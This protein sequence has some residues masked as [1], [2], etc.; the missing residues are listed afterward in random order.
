MDIREVLTDKGIPFKDTNNPYEILIQCT[1]GEHEDNNASLS[2]NLD[3]DIFNCWS[4]GFKG[5]STKF[6]ASIGVTELLES[7]SKQ[8]FRIRKLKSKIEDKMLK[9]SV[10]LP[11]DKVMVT[12]CFKNIH[13]RVLIEF[14]AFTTDSLGLSDYFCIPV[15]QFNKLRFIEG[16]LQYTNSDHKS[17]YNRRPEKAITADCL[18]P[19]DKVGNVNYVI[20]VEGIFDMLNMWQLG[21][22]NTLCIFGASNFS[23]KKVDLLDRVGVTRVDILM[24]PDIPGQKAA[25]NIEELLEK[26]DIFSRNIL[27]PEG[28]DPGELTQAQA[29]AY[30]K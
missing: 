16:R 24:D 8:P 14:G 15:Y 17:K 9:H 26:H 18:F 28:V 13:P 12:E 10:K 25:K 30:L 27:L 6:L 5:G 3:K 4:C 7:D 11:L 2:Y 21:Y 19:L 29:K 23:K 1:S 22:T 20:L